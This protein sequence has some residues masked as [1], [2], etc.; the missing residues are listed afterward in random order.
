MS[1]TIM[2]GFFFGLGVLLAVFGPLLLIPIVWILH[3]LL[4]RRLVLPSLVRR[5]GA[6]RAGLLGV[7]ISAAVATAVVA[8]SYVPGKREFDR[9]CRAEGIPTIRERVSVEGFYRTRLYP[10]EAQGFLGP[11]GFF[12]VEGPDM[13]RRGRT[14]RYVLADDGQ[15][16][17]EEVSEPRSRYGVRDV[18][19]ELPY[20]ITKHDKVVYEIAGGRELGRA[21]SI[22]YEGGPLSLFLGVYGMSSCPDVRSDEGAANFETYYELERIVLRNAG[23]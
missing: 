11:E 3:R 17:A 20:G 1:E 22:V 12:F 5:F 7:S 15:L 19:E 16:R 21:S 13:Y 2:E 4:I 9:L 14:I 18:F 23:G 6:A 10:Y 8:A